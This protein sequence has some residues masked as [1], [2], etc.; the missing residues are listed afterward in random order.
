MINTGKIRQILALVIIAATLAIAGAIGL[1][2]YRSMR[3]GSILPRLPKNIDVALQKIHYTETKD[4]VKKWDLVAD[5]AEYDKSNDTVQ[6]RDIRLQVAVPGETGA[7]VLTADKGI[8]HAG[9]KDIDLV[10]TIVA[11]SDSGMRFTTGRAAYVAARSMIHTN[12]RVK[13]TDGSLS[14]EGRGLEFMVETDRMRLLNEVT[15]VFTPG[16]LKK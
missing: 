8:Y 11:T 7:I 12:D 14:L 2:S 9:S 4:G 3:T 15:A 16:A 5:R 13:F 1:K 6:L 10:G